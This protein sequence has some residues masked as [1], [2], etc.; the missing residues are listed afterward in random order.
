MYA[1]VSILEHLKGWHGCVQLLEF[2]RQQDSVS[3]PLSGLGDA[4]S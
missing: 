4:S 1:E 3:H 2:S